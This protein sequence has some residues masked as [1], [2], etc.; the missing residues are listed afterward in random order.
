MLAF[1][2]GHFMYHVLQD[3]VL[4]WQGLLETVANCCLPRK[5][6]PFF[7]LNNLSTLLNWLSWNEQARKTIA[8]IE[9]LLK[10]SSSMVLSSLKR[11]ILNGHATFSF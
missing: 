11:I 1:H 10:V 5:V 2:A 8:A 6:K 9:Y 7:F 4:L 3:R